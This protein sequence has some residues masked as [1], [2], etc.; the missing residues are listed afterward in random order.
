MFLKEGVA[1]SQSLADLFAAKKATKA[2][3]PQKPVCLAGSLEENY[4][5]A[6][7]ASES[8]SSVIA[9]DNGKQRLE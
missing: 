3:K 9:P 4:P 5:P 7:P 6:F 8:M 1:L 2:D